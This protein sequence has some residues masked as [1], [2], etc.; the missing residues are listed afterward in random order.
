MPGGEAGEVG[1]ATGQ[2]VQREGRLFFAKSLITTEK[3]EI[4]NRYWGKR[5]GWPV[6]R[7]PRYEWDPIPENRTPGLDG[8]FYW[9]EVTESTVTI[10]GYQKIVLEVPQPLAGSQVST[11]LHAAASSQT[12]GVS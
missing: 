11:P 3:R 12:S 10:T 1:Y 2:Y 6:G 8:G 9:E 5:K 7:K 4:I